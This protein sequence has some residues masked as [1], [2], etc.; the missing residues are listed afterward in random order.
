M[1]SEEGR[2]VGLSVRR[3]VEKVWNAPDYY[4]HLKKG[5]HV[6]AIQQHLSSASFV[7]LDLANFFGSITATRITRSLRPKL[8]YARAREI[9]LLSTVS[10]PG[11]PSSRSLPYG[12]VQ[13][14]L[15][16]SVCLAESALGRQLQRVALDQDT[17][18]SVYVDDIIVSASDPDRV[19][20]IKEKLEG[21]ASRAGLTFNFVKSQG[22]TPEINAFNIELSQDAMRVTP[23]RF[24]EFQ[25]R[26]RTDTN[27]QVRQ[28][29]LAY[30][31]S[32]N[33]EQA[34]SL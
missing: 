33:A 21:A 30:V 5:G 20:S 27:K 28:A 19:T 15:L 25:T 29:L 34:D 1:P 2:A 11:V 8:G 18:V 10:S 9:A 7:R 31:S 16:A 24:L 17:R 12:F 22:P 6:A 32:V 14:P 26:Y 3:E 4:F 13:S 23:T